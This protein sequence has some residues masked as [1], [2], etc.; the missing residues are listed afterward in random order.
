M[1]VALIVF[2]FGVVVLIWELN[3]NQVIELVKPALSVVAGITN[4]G[5]GFAPRPTS[6]FAPL[7]KP[8]AL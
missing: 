7:R 2:I 8:M 1:K 3:S 6:N 4:I 5:N